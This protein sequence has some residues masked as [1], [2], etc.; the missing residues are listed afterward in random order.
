[1]SK[2]RIILGPSDMQ[3]VAEQMKLVASM[4]PFLVP[5][6][7]SESG[8]IGTYSQSIL[9][10]SGTYHIVLTA[11]AYDGKNEWRMTIVDA[12]RGAPGDDE[13]SLI[14]SVFFP[15]ELVNEWKCDQISHSRHF[16]C[17]RKPD[18]SGAH[19]RTSN[20]EPERKSMDKQEW[21]QKKIGKDRAFQLRGNMASMIG[22][23]I[24]AST[25]AVDDSNDSNVKAAIS[26][27]SRMLRIE[28]E[29]NRALEKF[30]E[31]TAYADLPA[32]IK[33]CF[34]FCERLLDNPE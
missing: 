22:V 16:S 19:V 4:K 21:G 15:G 24:A 13:V 14:M 27:M 26:G 6:A 20:P 30:N 31:N 1:M 9:L 29:M 17:E 12:D 33:E 23:S 28:P 18:Q 8:D 7:S 34:R 10:T 5:F 3:D 25:I 2:P 32:A 11:H